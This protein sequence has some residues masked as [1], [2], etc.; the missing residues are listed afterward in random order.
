MALLLKSELASSEKYQ[1]FL[2][3]C[4]QSRQQLQQTE[5]S[6]LSP[7][8]QRSQCRYFNIEK[9]LD[10]AQK[11][12]NSSLDTIVNLVPKIDPKIVQQKLQSKLGWLID[13]QKELEVWSQMVRWTRSLE[14]QLKLCGLNQESLTNFP[15]N[16]FFRE[17]SLTNNFLEKIRDYVATES[18]LIPQGQ[19]LLASSDVIESLF[20]KYKQFSSRCPFKQMGQMVLNLCLS[21]MNLTTGLVK[22]ALE[23][24]SYLDLEAW[25]DKVFGQSMLSKRKTVFSSALSDTEVA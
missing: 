3:Q 7:P 13:Y 9:L 22:Q 1:A 21:T 8:S 6:F 11:L 19:T 15:N 18:A 14:K 20:G 23:T 2:Q 10:W 16:P 17:V 4:N 25:T 5:I 24:V 12:L